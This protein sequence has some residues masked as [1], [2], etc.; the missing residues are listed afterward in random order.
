MAI[1]KTLLWEYKAN[2]CLP[3]QTPRHDCVGPSTTLE[4]AFDNDSWDMFNLLCENSE[5]FAIAAHF[6]FVTHLAYMSHKVFTWLL[7]WV[8]EQGQNDAV[9]NC[10][11]LQPDDRE[12]AE[13]YKE[14]KAKAGVA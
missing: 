14:R 7:P 9:R 3:P 6:Y 13:W 1:V 12:V 11:P 2:P 8:T 5:R 4:Y 10:Y